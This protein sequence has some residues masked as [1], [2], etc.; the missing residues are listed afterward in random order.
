MNTLAASALILGGHIGSLQA[1]TIG[2]GFV[3]HP[4]GYIMT[5]N[6]NLIVERKSANGTKNRTTCKNIGVKL[7]EKVGMAEVV[8]RDNVNRLA[9][10]KVNPKDFRRTNRYRSVPIV[11]LPRRSRA[12]WVNFN[13][14]GT[15][16]VSSN[17]NIVGKQKERERDEGALHYLSFSNRS[18]NPGDNIVLLG[19]P[20]ISTVSSTLKIHS[21]IVSS[22]VGWHNNSS[23]IQIDAATNS[24][25][26]GGPVMD[27]FGNVVAIHLATFDK[28]RIGERI[29][30]AR[31][32]GFSVKSSIA[33]QFLDV[34]N[35]DYP[36]RR[37]QSSM[38][39]AE[40]YERARKSVALIYCSD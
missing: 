24:G 7:G 9:V 17:S 2:T 35:I 3:F 19:Y 30:T 8:A 5:S 6:N 1:S 27:I 23:Q 10:I 28:H 36:R 32:F 12:G 25:S 20:L 14:I 31:G 34:S 11:H 16:R 21:G 33:T 15:Y 13:D 40:L 38:S 39:M 4:D 29:R 26:A 37:P 22:T 18:S